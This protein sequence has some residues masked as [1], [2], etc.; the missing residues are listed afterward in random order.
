MEVNP[1]IGE[2]DLHRPYVDN[3][4][5][6]SASGK[7]MYREKD[8]IDVWFDSGAMPFAQWHYPFEN[9][10]T[11][12]QSYPAD[13]IAEGVDQTRGWFFTLHAI[14]VML[15]D[16]IAFK[17]V[18][19]NGLVLDKD[20]NKMSKSKGNVVNP[21]ETINQ[22]GADATRW[23]LIGN[24][25]PWENLK[26]DIEGIQGVQRKFFGTLYNT[27]NF[28][29]LYANIDGFEYKDRIPV[30][31]RAELDRWIISLLNTLI[32]RVEKE[33]E[34]Y[35]PTR[36]IRL[37]EDFL[38]ENL[39]NW[40]V[41]LCRRRFWKGEMNQDK[42]AAYQTLYE[43]LE[44]MSILMSPFAPFYSDRLYRDLTKGQSVHLAFFPEAKDFETDTALEERMDMAQQISS[45]VHSVRK[46]K[47]VNQKVRQPLQKIMIPVFDP[48]TQAQLEAVKPIILSEVNVKEMVFLGEEADAIL[49]KK[50]KPDFKLLG[51]KL[52]R[53]M[54]DFSSI[55]SDFTQ[56]NIREL[57][58]KGEITIQI[59]ENNYTLLLSEVE[60]ISQDIPG[61][62][63]A[64]NGKFTVALDITVTE[65][66]KKEG[67]AREFVNRI[68]NLRKD[69]GFEVT[70]RVSIAV[71]EN[72]FWNEAV[73]DFGDYI[74]IETLSD[75]LKVVSALETGDEIEIFGEIGII[76]IDK[77]L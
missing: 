53:A 16:S 75:S 5:L 47:E 36:A 35:E 17:N 4:I 20:G 39:S 15:E 18:I 63:V 67:I 60:I 2:Y 69:K 13:F 34:D 70:D 51:P 31:E 40:Y 64:S 11:F 12:R 28:F 32:R 76:Q 45:L 7:P 10:E 56:K 19:A 33:M 23:Y 49:V 71:S 44:T 1:L 46:R 8:L 66:L 61:W 43:C 50:V 74:C 6:V 26:F 73:S 21:F 42:K 29:A 65:D 62:S 25:S 72:P 68:Q 38:S 59:A 27:Y 52:G 30:S 37:I 24:A 58:D 77:V 14:S 22:Y 3:I 41:R 57:E 55:V 54:K 9:Q 48:R